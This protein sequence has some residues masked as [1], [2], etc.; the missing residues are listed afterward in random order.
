MGGQTL[1]L[2]TKIT[3]PQN[4]SML[5]LLSFIYQIMLLPILISNVEGPTAWIS[6]VIAMLIALI[7]VK[8]IIQLQENHP[9]KTLLDICSDYMPK[10]L[11]KIIGFIYIAFFIF[12]SSILL[13]D[14]SE[15]VKM[16]MLFR[17]PSNIIILI[18]LLT[19]S[20][21]TQKGINTV[22][23]IAHITVI[24]AMIPLILVTAL[25][26]SYSSISNIFPIFP[27]DIKGILYT[28]PI[29]LIGFF[30]FVVLLFS[31]QY[32]EK[33]RENLKENKKYLYVSTSIYVLCFFLVM[34]KFGQEEAKRL[35]WP[36]LSIL[37]FLNIP[38]SFIESTEAVGISLSVVC[39]F[40]SLS[41]ILFFTNL[42][43]QKTL[44]TED[45]GYFIY[46]QTPI[47]YMATSLL[48]GINIIINYIKIPIYVFLVFNAIV[49]LSLIIIE[50]WRK[51]ANEKE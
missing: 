9:D 41:I 43:L 16:F 51:K 45:N 27:L 14:F 15:Q 13:K 46:I 18:I 17:T 3:A 6:I 12:A 34:F 33:H 35:V 2:K 48:P 19:S 37:K 21:A 7:F 11:V 36:F 23:Q 42:S 26:S 22:A 5:I 39:A 40:I 29:A 30:G 31:N 25:S 20:Y 28:V 4:T 38:G 49:L 50:K 10:I 47:I 1:K 8:P 44:R 24:I 32:V